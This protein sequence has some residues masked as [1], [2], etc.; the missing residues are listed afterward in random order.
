[1]ERTLDDDDELKTTV[2][3]RSGLYATV[4]ETAMTALDDDWPPRR[5]G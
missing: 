4:V 2:A 1:V 5:S 3:A